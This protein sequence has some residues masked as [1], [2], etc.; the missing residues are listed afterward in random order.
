[1]AVALAV[2][3]LMH[4]G[5]IAEEKGLQLASTLRRIGMYESSY[6]V[7]WLVSASAM[8]LVSGVVTSLLGLACGIQPFAT[9]NFL[10]PVLLMW[11][12][13]TAQAA[14]F[15]LL[16]VFFVSTTALSL[17]GGLV[18]MITVVSASIMGAAG[19]AGWSCG[20]LSY[21]FD[22]AVYMKEA[23]VVA[24]L[25]CVF[26]P[27]FHLGRGMFL[28]MAGTGHAHFD[29][30]GLF[31]ADTSDPQLGGFGWDS[32]GA[33]LNQKDV[34]AVW[35]PSTDPLVDY[36][37]YRNATTPSSGV[38]V[39]GNGTEYGGS[40]VY[41]ESAWN[42]DI[43]WENGLPGFGDVIGTL[44]G[45]TLLFFVLTW[46]SAQVWPGVDGAP[47]PLLFFLSSNYWG[48]DVALGPTEEEKRRARGETLDRERTLSATQGD[49][50]THKLSHSYEGNT[51]L[52]EVS[53]ELKRGEIFCLLGQNGAGKSTFVNCVSGL[54]TPSSGEGW[55]A[56]ISVRDDLPRL[57][58]VIGICPQHDYLWAEFT[59]REHCLM[60]SRFRGASW[61]EAVVE[62]Q[63]VL[64]DVK[65]EE[66]ADRRVPTYSGGMRRRLSVGLATVGD[67]LALFLDEPST[68]MD[69]LNRR[70]TWSIL[71]R[72]K[73]DR[74]MLLTTHSM[75]EADALGDTIAIMSLG[76]V[77]AL[78]TSLFLKEKYG[79]GYLVSFTGLPR[80]VAPPAFQVWQSQGPQSAVAVAQM[81]S[82]ALPM[83]VK[84]EFVQSVSEVMR[85]AK[86]LMR[87]PT[88]ATDGVG[89]STA[90]SVPRFNAAG[91]LPKFLE[92]M[93]SGNAPVRE[94]GLSQTTLEEVF[95][96][97]VVSNTE[98]NAGMHGDVGQLVEEYEVAPFEAG[99]RQILDE[100]KGANETIFE[101]VSSLAS[102]PAPGRRT[103][104]EVVE[105]IVSRGWVS[106][107][108]TGAPMPPEERSD[109]DGS[110]PSQVELHPPPHDQHPQH[111]GS[112]PP[113][114][115]GGY[116]ARPPVTQALPPGGT[117]QSSFV[118]QTIAVVEKC[119]T[120]F[121]RQ[122]W[123]NVS[124][125][126]FILICVLV[127]SLVMGDPSTASTAKGLSNK[128]A[129]ANTSTLVQFMFFSTGLLI[130]VFANQQADERETGVV[131]LMQLMGLRSPSYWAGTCIYNLAFFTMCT[132]FFL[133]STYV[134]ASGN[135][136]LFDGMGAGVLIAI[137]ISWFCMV[138]GMATLSSAMLSAR[139]SN[140][141]NTLLV[142]VVPGVGETLNQNLEHWPDYLACIPHLGYLRSLS[143]GTAHRLG[144]MALDGEN[145]PE[146]EMTR[147]VAIGG[148]MG[149]AL[150]VVG[151][152]L[153]EVLPAKHKP[154]THP[155]F[156]VLPLLEKGR[157][158]VESGE[159][160]ATADW[161]QMGDVEVQVE[162]S[163]VAAE[164]RRAYHW[165]VE[166]SV[167]GQEEPLILLSGMRK[168]FGELEV[169][170]G[171]DLVVGSGECFGLLGPNGAGKTTT[172]SLLIGSEAGA[173][174]TA[175]V[176]GLDMA[177]D[178]ATSQSIQQVK[179]VVGICPQF[180]ATYEDLT[181]EE[182][183]RLLAGVKGV[184][185]DDLFAHVRMVA[186]AVGLDGDPFWKR[187]KELSGG[188]RRRLTIAMAMCG[189]PRALFL[190][191]PTTGLDPDT[192]QSIWQ[193]IRRARERSTVLLTT[194]SMEEADALCTRLAI[195][196]QGK[197]RCIGE[198]LHLKSKFNEGMRLRMSLGD[199]ER[200]DE[201]TRFVKERIFPN[202][203]LTFE[204][205]GIREYLLPQAGKKD[206][207]AGEADSGRGDGGGGGANPGGRM[208]W[209][210]LAQGV[211]IS[212]VFEV[213]EREKAALGVTQWGLS[214]MSLEEVFVKIVEEAEGQGG[215]GN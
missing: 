32:L 117:Y 6:R 29:Q 159:P 205:G 177:G 110:A 115:G 137:S 36:V 180:D 107:E 68:G 113:Y 172:V 123:T 9:G 154:A 184:P 125:L 176:A 20:I 59:A 164:R 193:V 24:V 188:M 28:M 136:P 108:E 103:A 74:I 111:Y 119:W 213:M 92:Y 114:Q 201:V 121:L 65:L 27:A 61:A 63:R 46:Y 13:G 11:W 84:G 178:G 126:V 104:R 183:I 33:P 203:L 146:S 182:H 90:V 16:S 118:S 38:A 64:R 85:E 167:E 189:S 151:M 105:G 49:V 145:D 204:F 73:E 215:A 100:S 94:W 138:F 162:D 133:V 147:F 79:T 120:Y 112:Q 50:R 39:S 98:I 208:R 42:T 37:S 124:L 10:A 187:S 195:M 82:V 163:D 89:G 62:A 12:A 18:V 179:D 58:D 127:A 72:L 102:I 194:H 142:F 168:S 3:G 206:E 40:D 148:A 210:A 71:Q 149:V 190:D 88:L 99:L 158:K 57:R 66:A 55:V 96:K 19:T 156:F 45:L 95:L 132:S 56:G 81:G 141:L 170:R 52:R 155:L 77:R 165:A 14:F 78:G 21:G 186:E 199:P 153:H 17:V 47:L 23:S 83:D 34:A 130:P 196:S 139:T 166:G 191:E 192:R 86:R 185:R 198:P 54:H 144:S 211:K 150:A 212:K 69:P 48:L 175:R 75:E 60:Y 87:G 122:F 135:G 76:R 207:G 31:G 8:S 2:T 140:I 131:G 116:Y 109:D 143:L 173:T 91:G 129:T 80:P 197:L 97:L 51:A 157:S 43:A 35:C 15:Y 152:Y 171:V 101:M 30:V 134:A 214:Q 44:I 26:S 200:A 70:R 106:A 128:E 161:A 7:S 67:P 160:P 22:A 169:V 4:L 174:G 209:K 1:M 41:G 25:L 5:A 93:E 181:V 53:L 202:A